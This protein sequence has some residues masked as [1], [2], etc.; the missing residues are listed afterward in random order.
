MKCPICQH[1]ETSVIDSR[2]SGDGDSIRRRRECEK[3]EHRFTTHEH[4][5]EVYPLVVKKDGS[6][7]AFD[8]QKILKGVQKACEKRPISIDA[9]N[10]LVSDVEKD[11]QNFGQKEIP[12]EQIGELVMSRLK[13][14]DDVAYVRFASVYRSFRDINEFMSEIKDFLK[15]K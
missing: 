13:A 14:V 15:K 12:A 11:V 2:L 3:C 10:K 7:Q 1:P 9:I 4:V 5:E 6:R 8:S